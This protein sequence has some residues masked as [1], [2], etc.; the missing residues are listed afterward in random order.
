[1]SPK[2]QCPGMAAGSPCKS[3]WLQPQSPAKVHANSEL[4]SCSLKAIIAPAP[5]THARAWGARG[6]LLG[7]NCSHPGGRP[8][9]AL[10]R[11]YLSAGC[12]GV[13]PRRAARWLC[14][15]QPLP[16]PSEPT[17]G[18]GLPE[19]RPWALGHSP[20]LQIPPPGSRPPPLDSRPPPL[21]SRLWP[22]MPVQHRPVPGR[23]LG[24]F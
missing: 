4:G 11:L 2:S 18:A 9:C 1:M 10:S 21:D 19:T 8:A 20:G 15:P 23:L 7:W 14:P 16:P 13:S 3:P 5:G 24:C 6:A 22:S 17:A 12:L